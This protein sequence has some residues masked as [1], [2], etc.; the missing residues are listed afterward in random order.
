MNISTDC[1][2]EKQSMRTIL[3]DIKSLVKGIVL[4]ANVLPILSGYWLALFFTNASFL[5]YW[6]KFLYMTI[7]G[8][9][10]MAGALILNNWYEVDLDREMKRT[11]QRPTVTGNFSLKT[12]LTMGIISSLL[13]LGMLLFTTLEAFVY[14]FLGWFTYVVLY[15]F[16]SKRRYTL[17]TVIGSISG[18][19]TPLIGWATVT[20]AYHIVPIILFII[21]FIWQIPHTFAIAM[22]RYEEYKAANVPML[23]VVY[24]FDMTKRQ[25]AVYVACLLPLPLFLTSL[26]TPF[27]MIT[28][29]LN[30]VWLV[31]A[32]RG[33]F[34]KDDIKYANSMFYYSLTYL[35]IVFGMM[36]IITLPIFQ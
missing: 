10:L 19:F 26:G 33:L 24:G 13:G 35:T 28:S 12:V 20:S 2:M 14:G 4:I 34:K 8:T 11:Q 22:R 25:S 9:L 23:P 30:I 1:K 15:T 17:N 7:G 5:D 3:T 31:I 32:I 29:I 21:M 18:A 36:I 6:D 27:V 16:W